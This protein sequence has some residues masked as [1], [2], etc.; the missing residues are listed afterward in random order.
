[1]LTTV[2]AVVR[3]SDSCSAV[4]ENCGVE[5][6]SAHCIYTFT[7]RLAQSEDQDP[8]RRK[9][10]KP[11]SRCTGLLWV[12]SY[13]FIE[14]DV[15]CGCEIRCMKDYMRLYFICI[16]CHRL[17]QSAR[18]NAVEVGKALKNSAKIDKV[19]GY[20]LSTTVTLCEQQVR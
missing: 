4:G 14:R 17:Y 6:E 20:V 19:A 13:V 1:M 3:N 9:V 2:V 5:R 16:N 8:S 18:T 10:Y 11:I 15:A 7:I 12:Q